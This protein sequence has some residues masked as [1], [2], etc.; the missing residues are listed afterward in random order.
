[1]DSKDVQSLLV[2][3]FFLEVK[4]KFKQSIQPGQYFR[5]A[6]PTI[7]HPL[8]APLFVV[9]QD[10]N[11]IEFLIDGMNRNLSYL[12]DFA[13]IDLEQDMPHLSLEGPYGP[14]FDLHQCGSLLFVACG[15]GIVCVMSHIQGVIQKHCRRDSATQVIDLVWYLQEKMHFYW[16]E[17]RLK[18]LINMDEEFV[19]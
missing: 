1:V 7:K 3:G 8:S 2:D 14:V 4:S 9:W 11:G 13:H 16:V 6:F 10:D 12:K 5:V 17:S 15:I 18:E 19:R